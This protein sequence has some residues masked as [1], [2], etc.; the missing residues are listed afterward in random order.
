M[1][2]VIGVLLCLVLLILLGVSVVPNGP[3]DAETL[4]LYFPV[5]EDHLSS[6]GDAIAAVRVDWREMRNL[7]A[8]EQ[9]EAVM[10]MLMEGYSDGTLGQLVPSGTRMLSC[11][12][13]GSTVTV[14]FSGGN[15]LQI[16]AEIL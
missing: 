3:S 8:Q 11:Q 16:T 2:R 1:K 13:S 15:L 14:D 12:V 4:S 10:K 9:A 5:R 6:G 7:P